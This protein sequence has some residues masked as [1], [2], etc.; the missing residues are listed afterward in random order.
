MLNMPLLHLS[1]QIIKILV[2][3]FKERS[4]FNTTK[5]KFDSFIK[6][7]KAAYFYTGIFGRIWSLPW[8]I[9][10]SLCFS[11]IC[12]VVDKILSNLFS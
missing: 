7:T 5:L 9:F 3:P 10:M 6:V 4:D 12:Q 11:L 8:I 1:M 2:A